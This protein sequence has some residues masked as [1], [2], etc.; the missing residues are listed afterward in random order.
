MKGQTTPK[1]YLLLDA[2]ILTGYYIPES[3]SRK[4]A[5]RIKNILECCRKGGKPDWYLIVPNIV[6]AEVFSAFDKYCYA[7]WNSHVKKNLPKGLDKRRH[8]TIRQRFHE[9]ISNGHFFHEIELTT[10]HIFGIDLIAPV[11]HYFEFYRK[12]T[13]KIRKIPMQT[14]DMLILSM[15]IYLN[16]QY[17]MDRFL[18][19]TADRRM[20]N[21]CQK[22]SKGIKEN[23]AIKL[24][25]VE[26]AE[27]L[28]FGYDPRLY[29]RVLNLAGAS[30]GE[31]AAALG[32]FPLTI[33]KKS[34]TEIKGIN[35]PKVH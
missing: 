23:T 34:L 1:L 8:R 24:G 17:G 26:K 31:I 29:P 11:D 21:I 25:L 19:I 4:T 35:T 32:E 5:E 27:S 28:G 33:P 22:A 30:E 15:G 13:G 18:I 3:I 6:T 9:H 12:K 10:D 16:H 14:A 2:N 20:T 7:T